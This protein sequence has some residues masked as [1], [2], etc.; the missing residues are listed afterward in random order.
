MNRTKNSES[1]MFDYNVLAYFRCHRF[2]F[3]ARAVPREKYLY[4][5]YIPQCGKTLFPL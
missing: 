2:H 5:K 1:F 4:A 3:Y